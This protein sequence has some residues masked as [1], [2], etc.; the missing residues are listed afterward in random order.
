MWVFWLKNVLFD[1]ETETLGI[2]SIISIILYQSTIVSSPHLGEENTL[3]THTLMRPNLRPSTCLIL[4][5][6]NINLILSATNCSSLR[7]TSTVKGNL[8]IGQLCVMPFS[9]LSKRRWPFSR[10]I[11]KDCQQMKMPHTKVMCFFKKDIREKHLI[12]VKKTVVGDCVFLWQTSCKSMIS[13][14]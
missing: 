2:V 10:Q 11:L 14:I 13:I 5:Q 8:I 9:I 12:A 7:K 6:I 4:C 1:F 3:W